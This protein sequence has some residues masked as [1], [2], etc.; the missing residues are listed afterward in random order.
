MIAAAG[1]GKTKA[2]RKKQ[3]RKAHKKVANAEKAVA[4]ALVKEHLQQCNAL[5]DA[6]VLGEWLR[7]FRTYR[8]SYRVAYLTA[9]EMGATALDWAFQLTRTNMQRM[10][11][12]AGPEWGWND[13]SQRTNDT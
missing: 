11:E 5:R 7:G 9:A 13:K 8:S 6:T 4:Q 3:N 2:Q 12:R 1:S 10:Y